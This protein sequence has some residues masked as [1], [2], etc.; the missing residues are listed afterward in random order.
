MDI[1]MSF[2]GLAQAEAERIWQPFF[3]WVADRM[4]GDFAYQLFPP[5]VRTIAARHAWDPAYLK[6]YAPG[7]TRHDDR[8]GA[9]ADNMFWAGNLAEAGHVIYA[10][11]SRWLPV[12]LLQPERQAALADG[13]CVASRHAPVELHFQKGLA[14][15]APDALAA[16]RTTA[17]NPQVL[18]AFVLAI[19]GGEAPPAFSGL[20]GHEPDVA[21]ARRS[22]REVSLAMAELNKLAPD[23]GCYFAESDFFEPDWQRAY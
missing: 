9:P 22:A 3:D 4:P 21:A 20:A 12:A 8:P 15:A 10:Y 5:A 1:R 7:I 2:H 11:E 18:D 6:A 23:A 13:L 17:M 16:T 14:G 19:T